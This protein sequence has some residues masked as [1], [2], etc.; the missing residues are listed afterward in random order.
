MATF[1]EAL[2]EFRTARQELRDTQGELSKALHE[3]EK[4]DKHISGLVKK[5]TSRYGRL[6]RAQD[7]LVPELNKEVSSAQRPEKYEAQL[8]EETEAKRVIDKAAAKIEKENEPADTA[9]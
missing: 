3:R 7:N 4:L 8:A 2:E 9:E 1:D 5:Y 6:V